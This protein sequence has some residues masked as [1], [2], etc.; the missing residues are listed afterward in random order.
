M[1]SVITTLLFPRARPLD[2]LLSWTQGQWFSHDQIE[3][4]VVANGRRRTLEEEVIGILRAQDRMV[5][6]D[7][8]NEMALYDA[9]ARAASG[10]WLLFTEPHC[11]ADG[12]CIRA[13]TDYVIAGG[14]AGACVRTIPAE[15]PCRV[16]CME[17]R[18]YLEDASV[19]TQGN[20]WRKFTKR[21]FLLRRSAYEDVGGFEA[22]HLRF[23]EITIAAKLHRQGYRL[24]FA[25]E[26][27]I[28]HYNSTTLSELLG[29]VWEYRRI[30][31]RVSQT[32]PELFEDPNRSEGDAELVQSGR[33]LMFRHCALPLLKE[34]F[35]FAL[36]R[37]GRPGSRLM[38][39]RLAGLGLQ[40]SFGPRFARQMSI[41]RAAVRFLRAWIKFHA[42]NEEVAYDAYKQMWQCFGDLSVAAS[43]DTIS[44]SRVLVPLPVGQV[45][46]VGELPGEHLTGFHPKEEWQGR[47]FRWSGVL[48]ALSFARIAEPP[49]VALDLLPVASPTPRELLVYWNDVRLSHVVECSTPTRLVY[50]AHPAVQIARRP[51][52][53]KVDLLT[54][55]CEPIV[56]RGAEGRALGVPLLSVE[57]P[58]RLD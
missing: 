45:C 22:S 1:V 17:A 34:P 13:L 49:I 20:D 12:H 54:L 9:G 19:W 4:I 11:M 5:R 38:A 37:I 16:A 15:E 18:M 42:R 25:P 58:M 40:L 48:S 14:L 2:C 3:L 55:I 21:G 27:T 47:A 10:S 50:R 35:L 57:R 39:G 33:D 23:G 56:P 52:G 6:V 46:K 41:V 53:L 36:R 8:Q 32:L 43:G 7:S 24:G 44:E 28:T 31:R 30:E 51:F 26:A 29:Y